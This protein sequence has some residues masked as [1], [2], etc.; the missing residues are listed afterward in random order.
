MAFR[1]KGQLIQI[2]QP[3]ILIAPEC[4]HPDNSLVGICN[5]DYNLVDM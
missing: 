3:D 2:E 1:N 4:E 5:P